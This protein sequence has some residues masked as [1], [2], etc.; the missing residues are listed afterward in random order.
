MNPLFA[1]GGIA[2][3]LSNKD[4]SEAWAFGIAAFIH[5]FLIINF[6]AVAPLF[7]IWLERKVA[8]RIQD[9]LGPDARRRKI[10]LAADPGRRRQADPEGGPRARRSPTGCSSGSRPYLVFVASFAAFI[11]LPWSDGW[12]AQNLDVGIFFMLAVMSLEVIGVIFAGYSSGSKWALFGGM[13]EAAQV[14]S[15]EIPMAIC[16]LVPV[17]ALGT[18]NMVEISQSAVGTFC[19]LD[20]VSR[21]VLFPGLLRVLHGRDGERASGLRSTWPRPRA[22]WSAGF[23]TEYSGIRWSYFF[24]AEYASMFA[25]SGIATALFLGGWQTGIGIEGAILDPI[26]GW[27][28]DFLFNGFVAGELHRQP[29]GMRGLHHQGVPAGVRADVGAV[30]AAAAADRPGDDHLPQVS[31]ADQLL[32]VSGRDAVAAACL[33][34]DRRTCTES[35]RTTSAARATAG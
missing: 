32:F 2:E 28:K 4:F 27:G 35:R 24:M 21:P 33:Q 17:T 10:R 8:G 25:V 3:Y 1:A 15:Y 22:N 7:Y 19:E 16:A 20:G 14:V 5:A 6:F 23:H 31:A 12:V 34:G 13:R 30:D 9:R 18:L 29:R 11:V 26:R